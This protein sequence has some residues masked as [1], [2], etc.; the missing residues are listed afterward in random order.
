[1][2]GMLVNTVLRMVLGIREEDTANKVQCRDRKM[3]PKNDL[4]DGFKPKSKMVQG[5]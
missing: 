3:N 2:L 5:F 4:G 1:M